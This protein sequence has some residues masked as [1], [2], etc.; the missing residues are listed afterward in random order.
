VIVPEGSAALID[1]NAVIFPLL[2]FRF[3]NSL[4]DSAH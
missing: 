1:E 2:M 3:D 4:T